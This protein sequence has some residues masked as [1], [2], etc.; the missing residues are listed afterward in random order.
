[1]LIRCREV[2]RGLFVEKRR[3]IGRVVGLLDLVAKRRHGGFF[4]G[5]KPRVVGNI[6]K[7]K[8]SVCGCEGITVCF[9]TGK[10]SEGVTSIGID[11]IVARLGK[12]K[13]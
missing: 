10:T 9:I 7:T 2:G 12:L 1:M 4:V 11:G 8:G 13:E 3:H 5:L 6:F